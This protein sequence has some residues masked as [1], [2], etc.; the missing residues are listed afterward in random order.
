MSKALLNNT[1]VWLFSGAVMAGGTYIWKRDR[2]HNT[3]SLK[4]DA[5]TITL[6]S[7]L[8]RLNTYLAEQRDPRARD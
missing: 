7:K 8:N 4:I 3:T 5:Q 6:Q 2:L 1:G